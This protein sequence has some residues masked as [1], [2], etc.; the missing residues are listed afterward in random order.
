VDI[1]LASGVFTDE[2]GDQAGAPLPLLDPLLDLRLQFLLEVTGN[3][4]P[5]DDFGLCAVKM[6]CNLVAKRLRV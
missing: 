6:Y 5:I 4:L 2:N 3:F 1:L